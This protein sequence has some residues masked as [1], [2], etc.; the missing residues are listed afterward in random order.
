MSMEYQ[1][2]HGGEFSWSGWR[3]SSIVIIMAE[4]MHIIKHVI[5]D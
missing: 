2:V 3:S 5:N 1:K 4:L